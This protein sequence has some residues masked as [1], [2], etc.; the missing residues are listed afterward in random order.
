MVALLFSDTN[1]TFPYLHLLAISAMMRAGSRDDHM[2]LLTI[3]LDDLY[4]CLG[5]VFR[6]DEAK[7]WI[8]EENHFY[9]FYLRIMFL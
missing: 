2:V 8:K 9:S 1:I 7:P 4:N 5:P 3:L 6:K